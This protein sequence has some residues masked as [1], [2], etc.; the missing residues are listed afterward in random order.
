MR[1]TNCIICKSERKQT[2]E[3]QG[4]RDEY[5]DLIDPAYQDD[6]RRLAV[7]E[8]CGFVYHDP[9]LDERDI[10]TLY[11]KFRD[12]S[13]RNESPDAYFDRITSLPKAG[14]ENQAKVEWLR[15]HA[16]ET[17]RGGGRLLDI[18]C[19]GGVFIHTFLQNFP[20]WDAAGVEPTVAFAEL[21]GRR[22][23]RPVVAGSYRSGLFGGQ[24]FDLI[25]VNQVLE[26]VIEPVAFLADVRKD[27]ADSGFVYLEVP[28]VLDL[29]HLAPTHDRFMMQHLW[30]FSRS[31]LANVCRRAGYDV[32]A[33]DQQVTVRQKRNLVALLS[34]TTAVADT[35]E[36]AELLRD[37]PEWV[38]SLREE[39]HSR[40]AVAAAEHA[41]AS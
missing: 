5:L 7:C 2:L 20:G 17:L 36:D 31:S 22:L 16:A 13:F 19:G 38:A 40:S 6:P 12:A 39:Y 4:F 34:K 1:E 24:R 33:L 41:A 10:E 11:D 35:L 28:D 18:G 30:V 37:R 26:H 29:G 3:E 15:V 27:L 32:V 25:S 14:S 21:A 8:D 9:Q 23:A